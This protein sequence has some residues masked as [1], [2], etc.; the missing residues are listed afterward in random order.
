MPVFARYDGIDGESQDAR[1]PRWIDVLAV[2]WGAHRSGTGSTGATRRRVA[3]NIE[4]LGLM[5][6]YEAAATKL[7]EACLKGMVI[8]RLDI[9]FTTKSTDGGTVTYLAYELANV[10][11]TSF[12]FDAND[13]EPR[14]TVLAANAFE[15]IKVTYTVV[16]DSGATKGVVETSHRVEDRH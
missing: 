10:M 5:F 2:D 11:V 1:H 7:Q 6:H 16:D 9:E 12:H 3:A 8:P 4:D 15:E 13:D 14:P